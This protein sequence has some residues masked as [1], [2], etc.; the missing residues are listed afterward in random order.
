MKL[1]YTRKNNMIKVKILTH[2]PSVDPGINHME[3]QLVM[4]MQLSPK[5]TPDSKSPVSLPAQQST[6]IIDTHSPQK[7]AHSDS[8]RETNGCSVH[9]IIPDYTLL[10]PLLP[11]CNRCS[12]PIINTHHEHNSFQ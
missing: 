10:I 4:P 12:F 8:K 9:G 1:G 7:T 2:I 3:T 11:G 6:L 5:R